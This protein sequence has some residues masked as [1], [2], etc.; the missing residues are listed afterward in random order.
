MKNISFFVGIILLIIFIASP[1]G[2][3]SN[4]GAGTSA[5]TFLRV[6]VG[7][8]AQAMAGAMVGLADDEYAGYYNPAGLAQLVPITEIENEF[9][10]VK[11]VEG[12]I[13]KYFASEYNNY[14]ADIQSGYVTFIKRQGYGG[15]LGFSIDYFNYGTFDETDVNNINTGTFSASDIAFALNFG[16]RVNRNFYWGISG[17]FIYEKLQDYS[18]DGLGLDGGILYKLDDKRTR[19]G[20]TI[21]NIGVQL[22]GLT[23]EHKDKLPGGAQLG[24]SHHLK[25][26]PIIFSGQLDYPFDYDLSFK[27]GIE[28]TGLNP[29]LIRLGWDSSGRNYKSGSSKDSLG[30]LSGGFGISWRNYRFDYSYSSFADIGGSHRISL[31]GGF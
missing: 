9:G 2:Y 3:S 6:G 27:F 19:L 22:R 21:K 11:E 20:A 26:A 10:E 12:N 4:E 13:S 17:K 24:I 15:M 29:V 1:K 31:S 5:Y 30:G 23:S 14:I 28:I 8:R 18:S 25:G 16:Q 7:A